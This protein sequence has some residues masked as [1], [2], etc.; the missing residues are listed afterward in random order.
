MNDGLHHTSVLLHEAV[1]AV[2]GQPASDAPRCFV[3]ATFGRGGHSRAL[4]GRM[5]PADRLI[6]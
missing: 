2:F 5:G 6:A 4:L 3:D 1:D